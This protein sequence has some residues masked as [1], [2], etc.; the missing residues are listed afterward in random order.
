MILIGSQ[1]LHLRG[2]QLR[3]SIDDL[4][5]ICHKDE[6]KIFKSLHGSLILSEEFTQ[7]HRYTFLMSAEFP[8]RKVE[9]DTEN[10]GSDQLLERLDNATFSILGMEVQ[11]PSIE[12]LFLIKRAHVNIPVHYAKTMLDIIAMTPR[13]GAFSPSQHDFY[14]LRKKECRER[15]DLHRQRFSLSVSNDTFFAVSDHVRVYVHDDLH[16]VLAFESNAPLY[17]RCKKDLEKAKIDVDLFE[18]LSDE[19]K[20]RMVQEEFMVIGIERF[21]MQDRSLQKNSVYQQGMHKTIRDLFVGY[22][23][24]FCIDHINELLK[25]PAHDFVKAF[26]SAETAGSLREVKI[27]VPEFTEAHQ[28]IWELINRNELSQALSL[29]ED[30]ARRSD[31]G[32]DPHAFLALGVIF[33]K[34]QNFEHAEIWFKRC[35]A[36]DPKNPSAHLYLGLLCR[37]Q[38]RYPETISALKEA[39]QLGLRT[40]PLFYNMGLALEE[41]GDP[42]NAR[43]AYELACRIKPESTDVQTRLAALGNG[44]TQD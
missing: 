9:F 3:S 38:K 1:A 41:T 7:G 28:K 35:L 18:E 37:T 43:K 21:F 11:L 26:L 19:N 15:Y 17:K 31:A 23:Q 22:F 24:D 40:Y 25:P 36:R 5:L 27:S 42:V 29:S 33:F 10:S 8:F 34:S 6:I 14:K 12:T 16:D 4:D 2:L 20:L 44:L 39:F 32:G 30:M 13:L